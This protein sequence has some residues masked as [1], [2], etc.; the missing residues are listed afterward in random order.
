MHQCAHPTSN[1]LEHTASLSTC[2][3][4]LVPTPSLQIALEAERVW[5]YLQE[6]LGDPFG[7]VY[8]PHPHPKGW[9]SFTVPPKFLLVMPVTLTF[10]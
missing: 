1:F 3:V 2:K 4:N 10:W 6:R 7:S 5:W 8:N 9:F